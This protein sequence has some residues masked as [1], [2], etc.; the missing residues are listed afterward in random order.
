MDSINAVA[1]YSVA[2]STESVQSEAGIRVLKK[3]QDQDKAVLELLAKTFQ[4]VATGLGQ[5]IDVHA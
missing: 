4:A 1:A 2:Q 3:A 5:N